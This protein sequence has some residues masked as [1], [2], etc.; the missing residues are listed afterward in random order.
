MHKGIK[1]KIIIKEKYI[2]NRY[3]VE[4]WYDKDGIHSSIWILDAEIDAEH[5]KY[6]QR[7]KDIFYGNELVLRYLQGPVAVPILHL[8]L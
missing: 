8:H 7:V 6:S 1:H 3:I 4:M 2:E 5:N